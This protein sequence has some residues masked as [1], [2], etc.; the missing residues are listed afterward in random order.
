MHRQKVAT[1]E[2]IISCRNLPK[3]TMFSEPNPMA[4]LYI[5]QGSALRAQRMSQF[6]R[7]TELEDPTKE[8]VWQEKARSE[9]VIH[10]DKP[11]FL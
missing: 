5:E 8:L 9:I 2:L 10:K 3:V 6:I 7:E 4:V 11:I 1:V